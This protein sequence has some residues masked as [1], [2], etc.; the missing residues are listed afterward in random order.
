MATYIQFTYTYTCTCRC[1][2]DHA[3]KGHTHALW[4]EPGNEASEQSLISLYIAEHN[5]LYFGTTLIIHL[6]VWEHYLQLVYLHNYRRI[7]QSQVFI[8]LH[9]KFTHT[10][11]T[12]SPHLVTAGVEL[13]HIGAHNTFTH[14]PSKQISDVETHLP[15]TPHVG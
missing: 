14:T 13:Y 12:L 8:D 10:T 1:L 2:F 5:L 11:R 9:S 15:M 6:E 4:G 3:V 7:V